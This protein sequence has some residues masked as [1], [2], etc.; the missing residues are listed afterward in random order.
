ME[1]QAWATIPIFM[2]KKGKTSGDTVEQPLSERTWQNYALENIQMFQ[3]T[4]ALLCQ[5]RGPR[6]KK[7][8]PQQKNTNV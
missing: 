5:W 1:N 6:D 8:F 7:D 2:S 3:I 4:A